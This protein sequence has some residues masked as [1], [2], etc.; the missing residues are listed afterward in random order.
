MS[1]GR[2]SL[3]AYKDNCASAPQLANISAVTYS[4]LQNVPMSH[5]PKVLSNFGSRGGLA[6]VASSM[7]PTAATLAWLR[8]E[9]IPVSGGSQ[10]PDF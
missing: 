4:V 3:E 5:A 10:F 2:P 8:N 1:G 7:G 9:T 6:A